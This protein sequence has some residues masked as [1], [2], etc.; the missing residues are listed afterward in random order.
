MEQKSTQEMNPAVVPQEYAKPQLIEYGLVKDI[1]RS[2]VKVGRII[3]TR[4]SREDPATE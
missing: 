3:E 4:G 2:I 1:V